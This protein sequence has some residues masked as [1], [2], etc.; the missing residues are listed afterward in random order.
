MILVRK[1]REKL[2]SQKVCR[3]RVGWLKNVDAKSAFEP[4]F[5]VVN[6]DAAPAELHHSHEGINAFTVD[7]IE[8][9]RRWTAGLLVA[10]LPLGYGAA[11]HIEQQRENR[12]THT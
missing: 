8:Q 3:N 6:V 5:Q 1:Q 2:H 4:F 7:N 10:L 9:S 11:A 12:L